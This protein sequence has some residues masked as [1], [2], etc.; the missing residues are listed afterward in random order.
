VSL[1]GEAYFEVAKDASKPFKV[2][3]NN[4][5]TVEVLGT[6]FNIMAYAD[7]PFEATTLLEGKVKINGT[8]MLPGQ[9]AKIKNEVPMVSI[10]EIDTRSAI[11]WKNGITS[12]KNADIKTIM[13]I[14]SRWYDV[15]VSYLG[16]I[17]AS[18]NYVGGIPRNS[19]LDNVLKALAISGIHFTVTGK[20]I[21]VSP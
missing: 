7:E 12:F 13:R 18:E 1:T 5:N 17:P 20:K 4:K 2:L 9:Q 8:I 3:I 15:D 14:V 16:E 19:S 21:I 6:H 11:A 10:S